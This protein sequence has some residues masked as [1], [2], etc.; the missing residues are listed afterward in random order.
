[1]NISI[2]ANNI[3]D[4]IIKELTIESEK[5]PVI[6]YG[7][8]LLLISVIKVVVFVSVTLILGV[9]LPAFVALLSAGIYRF[10]SGGYHFSTFTKCLLAGV[11][12]FSLLGFAANHGLVLNRGIIILTFIISAVIAFKYAPVGCETKPIEDSKR[13]RMKFFSIIYLLVYF[14]LVY[15]L[16]TPGSSN[17]ILVA[18]Y[19][20]ILWQ[21]VSITPLAGKFTAF[22]NKLV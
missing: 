22:L 9:F 12:I 20:G 16:L 11:I 18:S 14:V 3:T 21:T 1:M 8:E 4:Y 13:G 6:T 17:I 19:L 7:M 2:I 15:N 10:L 5:K